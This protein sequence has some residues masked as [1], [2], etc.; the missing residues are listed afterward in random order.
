M[1]EFDSWTREFGND[2][3]VVQEVLYD[4]AGRMIGVSAFPTARVWTD[5]EFELEL[6]GGRDARALA[7][8]V[9]A[10]GKL[11]DELDEAMTF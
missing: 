2:L 9:E 11:L 10:A 3:S 8:Q 5:S 4:W 1:S 6:S 7:A